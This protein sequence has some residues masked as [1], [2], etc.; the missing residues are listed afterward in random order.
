MASQEYEKFYEGVFSKIPSN[1]KSIEEVRSKFEQWMAEYPSL[2]D[3]RIEPVSIGDR[4]ASWILA[5]AAS[6]KKIILFLHGGGF[7]A[8]SLEAHKNLI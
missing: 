1:T 4:S 7:V 5:P 8:G 6:R 3:L 2:S